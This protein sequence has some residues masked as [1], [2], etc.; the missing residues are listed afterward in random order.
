MD[1]FLPEIPATVKQRIEGLVNGRAWRRVGHM[2][3]STDENFANQIPE[4]GLFL[5]RTDE[6]VRDWVNDKEEGHEKRMSAVRVFTADAV[7]EYVL[8]L[9]P[10]ARYPGD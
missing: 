5:I 9:F 7:R 4:H 10:V 8:K 6:I 1:V 2:M 3:F